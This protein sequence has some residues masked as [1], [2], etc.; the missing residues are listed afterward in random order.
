MI[1]HSVERQRLIDFA[2]DKYRAVRQHRWIADLNI[3]RVA[4]E[5]P[6]ANHA[7]RR[8]RTGLRNKYFKRTDVAASSA[9][10]I[11]IFG[12]KSSS[13]VRRFARVTTAARNSRVA[14]I[15]CGAAA[16]QRA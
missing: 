6:P 15:D 1:I 8:C 5:G 2:G 10:R 14:G 13:L 16:E 7:G 12:T 9:V 11:A 4:I 3:I